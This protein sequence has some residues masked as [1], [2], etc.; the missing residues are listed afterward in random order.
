M[1]DSVPRYVARNR[2]RPFIFM[3]NSHGDCPRCRW[4]TGEHGWGW[5]GGGYTI[6]S[7]VY[8]Q[9][10]KKDWHD[11]DASL[12][13]TIHDPW[14]QKNS[15]SISMS[16]IYHG[17]IISVYQYS[18]VNFSHCRILKSNRNVWNEIWII[19]VSCMVINNNNWLHIWFKLIIIIRWYFFKHAWALKKLSFWDYY[20]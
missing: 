5:G 1:K 20:L 15:P 19:C 18:M 13:S 12:S 9:I 8:Q 3:E 14:D 4:R 17:S 11:T 6:I 10:N 7:Y 2:T 16:W